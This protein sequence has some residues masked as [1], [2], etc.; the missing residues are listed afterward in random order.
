[1]AEAL[2]KAKEASLD[3]VEIAPTANPPVCRIMNFGKFIYQQK[4]KQQDSKKK[5][6][7]TQVKEVKFRPNIDDHDYDFK[8]KNIL[9]FLAHGD[10]V[11]ATVQFRGREMARRENGQKVLDRLLSDL[12][13]EAVDDSRSEMLGNRLLHISAPVRLPEKAARA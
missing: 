3:L 1:M 2:E 10:K 5:Q 11:K 8:I 6:K 9:K 12:Q 13:G 4:K 7:T